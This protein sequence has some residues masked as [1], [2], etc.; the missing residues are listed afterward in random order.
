[1]DDLI[2]KTIVKELS[3]EDRTEQEIETIVTALGGLI[4]ELMFVT[5][6]ETMNDED[7]I[8]F[9]KLVQEGDQSIIAKFIEEHVKGIDSILAACS[10]DIINQF[11]DAQ[12]GT[13]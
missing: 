8:V 6:V 3:L 2:Q 11:K 12:K 13:L 1:M 7:V 5:I 9:E 4:L 10:K